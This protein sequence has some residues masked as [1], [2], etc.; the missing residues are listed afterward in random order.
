MYRGNSLAKTTG[1]ASIRQNVSVTLNGAAGNDR[2]MVG[3]T[4]MEPF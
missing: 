4:G 3:A 2:G 1:G